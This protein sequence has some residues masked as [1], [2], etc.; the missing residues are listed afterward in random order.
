M[1][2]VA[3]AWVDK[4]QIDDPLL[5]ALLRT[6]AFEARK[7]TGDCVASQP[8][9]AQILGVTDRCVR[10]LLRVLEMAEVIER[11]RQ[12][13]GRYGRG[14][15]AIVLS[16]DRQFDIS[17]KAIRAIRASLRKTSNRNEVPLQPE[18]GSGEY[19]TAYTEEPF[20]AKN[21]KRGEGTYT[22]EAHGSL[23]SDRGMDD[24]FADE[25]VSNV[26]PFRRERLA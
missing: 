16:L 10:T 2:K 20:Q 17:R 9:L 19:Y 1:S 13:N 7:N 6:L 21:S 18:R 25:L 22:H 23:P 26:V 24:W 15:D 11:K 12:S 5:K 4:Q 3:L 14:T 8:R